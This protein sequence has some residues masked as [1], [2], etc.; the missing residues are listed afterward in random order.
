M[1]IAII[2]TILITF[3]GK[4][5]GLIKNGGVGIEG[6]EISF[7]GRMSEFDYKNADL[8]IDGENKHAT[9]PGLINAHIHSPLTICRG[10]VHDVP[11][12]EY[13]FKGL[14][15]FVNHL[16]SEDSILGTK[17]TVIEGI[18]S[19]TTTF[20]EYENNVKTL[21]ENVYL[22]YNTRVVAT[23]TINERGY[24]NIQKPTELYE[25]N[26]AKGEDAF[27]R[28]NKL[29]DDYKYNELVTP[30]YGPQA[31][32][33][34]TLDFL[35][36]IKEEALNNDSKLHMHI[37]QGARERIQIAKRYGKDM[38]AVKL[39]K[40]NDL[41]D[42]KLIAA[43]IHDTTTEERALL[44]KN[45]VKMVGCPS[46]ISKVDGIIPPLEDYIRLGGIAGIGTDEAPGSGHHNLLNEIKMASI[47]SKT[48][49]QDPTVLPP[50]E[51]L[52]L[53]TIGG[54]K[55]LGL[56]DQIGSLKVGKKADVIT[57]DLY[58]PY[59]TPIISTPFHNI[60]ANL[61]YSCKGDETDTVIINGK[62]ILLNNEFLDIDETSIIDEVNSRA[63]EIF[64]IAAK[65][66]KNS[67]SK[68]VE[69][70]KFGFI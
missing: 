19:G 22:P 20:A 56:E 45:G 23:E 1:D 7:I 48:V 66:W 3:E 15:V 33:M 27:K 57:I 67:G 38:T 6:D 41:L 37:A 34:L 43:H 64:E 14:S 13:M 24:V 30:M 61:V 46:A 70:H 35:R 31:L 55:V 5:L 8:I 28:A 10:A 62:P 69:Y 26:R 40:T 32:D 42:S 21:V 39:L 36:E 50:W 58:R 18:R 49:F 65:D 51:S 17:L 63:K 29:Y 52:K 25:F 44:I 60:L 9:L 2:N 16:K 54:A 47:L 12:I 11:E 68:M 53:A 4:G 59:L